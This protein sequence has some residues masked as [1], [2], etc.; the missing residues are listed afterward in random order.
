MASF[1]NNN[2]LPVI[3]EGS[4]FIEL[5]DGYSLKIGGY[6]DIGASR[7]NQDA[8]CVVHFKSDRLNKSGRAICVADGHGNRGETAANVSV[9]QMKYLIEEKVDD[10]I[11]NPVAFL[12]IAFKDIHEEIKHSLVQELVEEGCCATIDDTTGDVL[13][14]KRVIKCG[15][16]FSVMIILD[17]KLYIANVG[18]STGILYSA[19]PIFKKSYLN[20]ELNPSALPDVSEELTNYI[21]LTG[22]HSPDN[23]LEYIKMREFKSSKED[24]LSAE[25]MCIYDNQSIG[26]KRQCPYVF[27]MSESGIPTVRPEDGSFTFYYKNVRK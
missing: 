25:L 7:I 19:T 1:N 22:D 8:A 27:N 21:E 4:N 20:C 2:L 17:K 14:Y 24:P 6:T 16:T 9:K 3:A 11:Q 13:S 10:L 26:I 5:A 23:P 18:D 12:E 15:T